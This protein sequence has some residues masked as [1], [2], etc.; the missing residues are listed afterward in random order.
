MINFKT[1]VQDEMVK[2]ELDSAYVLGSEDYYKGRLCLPPMSSI[3][4]YR[5]YI[6][7]YLDAQYLSNIER[8]EDRVAA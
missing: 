4:A 7:G 1:L 8:F 3:D 6:D 2:A 5:D